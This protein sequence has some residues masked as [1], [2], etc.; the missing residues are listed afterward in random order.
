[1]GDIDNV[2]CDLI[3]K[4]IIKEVEYFKQTNGNMNASCQ[5][6]PGNFL[7]ARFAYRSIYNIEILRSYYTDLLS[8]NEKINPITL[9]YAYMMESTNP[10]EYKKV[11]NLIEKVSK[12]KKTLVEIILQ[13]YMIWEKNV[14]RKRSRK[15][16]TRQDSSNET[17][18]ETYMRGELK[19]Y[20]ENTLRLILKYFVEEYKKG[21][22]LVE[23]NMNVLENPIF[24][25]PKKK[26]FDRTFLRELADLA[27]SKSKDLGVKICVSICDDMGYMLYFE[28]ESDCLPVSIELSRLKA[29]TS[30]I[31]KN[32]TENLFDSDLKP[33]D[34][35]K[36]FGEDLCFL[37]GGSPIYLE[38]RLVGALG[39]SGGTINQDIEILNY[40][41]KN[42]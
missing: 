30:A 38:D 8:Y 17:S 21:K 31:F 15:L 41:I 32:S 24:Y 26:I 20:S 16:Y 12:Y 10:N 42:I 27:L 23:L 19:T 6:Q 39:I 9:K 37:P 3:R 28:K 2:K 18:I 36:I 40:C 29:R 11:E 14:D 13:I 7:Y 34:G 22:N 4:I 1:M 35:L 5:K 33:L 25:K